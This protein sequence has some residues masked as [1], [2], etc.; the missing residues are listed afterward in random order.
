MVENNETQQQ[1]ITTSGGAKYMG[2]CVGN[3]GYVKCFECR[4]IDTGKT[5]G[6]VGRDSTGLFGPLCI[7]TVEAAKRARIIGDYAEATPKVRHKSQQMWVKTSGGNRYLATFLFRA[8]YGIKCFECRNKLSGDVVGYVGQGKN[9]WFGPLCKSVDA[10][11]NRAKV[12]AA[13]KGDWW[14]KLFMSQKTK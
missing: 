2:T 1:Y 7:D 14:R 8:E 12:V 3:I 9:G 13:Y 6:F 11:I 5:V 10:A 4:A